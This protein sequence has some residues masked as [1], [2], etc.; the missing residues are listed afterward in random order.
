[1]QQNLQLFQLL[2]LGFQSMMNKN[3]QKKLL[4]TRQCSLVSAQET[5]CDAKHWLMWGQ[6]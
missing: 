2:L 1:M 6:M 4:F 5:I 3:M